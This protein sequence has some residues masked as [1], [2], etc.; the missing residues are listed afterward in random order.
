M[1]YE[2]AMK[3]A[4][5]E[6]DAAKEAASKKKRVSSSPSRIPSLFDLR[7]MVVARFFSLWKQKQ[8]RIIIIAAGGLLV[9]L[10][11]ISILSSLFSAPAG[12]SVSYTMSD[13]I[14]CV[15][16]DDDVKSGYAYDAYVEITNTGK[17][18]IY[19]KDM[20][21]MIQD[22]DGNRVMIDD[23]ISVFPAII[24][25]G[26]KGYIFNRF[27]TELT[28]VY[29][30]D[31]ELYL[32]PSYSVEEADAAPH[33]FPVDNVKISEGDLGQK[34][35]AQVTNDTQDEVKSMYVVGVCYN[36][37]GHCV[38]ISGSFVENV[39]PHVSVNVSFDPMT[40]VR[41]WRNEQIVDYM[42]YAY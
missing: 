4:V 1:D 34:M 22:E 11:L 23:A 12:S 14:L 18:S 42:I 30:P 6:A 5:E 35:T 20:S 8:G 39:E 41:P 29:D 2:T 40:M 33:E 10:I 9:L 3:K 38:G 32:V 19:A 24:A 31:M 7:D 15:Y 21:F 26:E 17:S 28:G 36:A 25:P 37:D 27:G 16:E 13:A